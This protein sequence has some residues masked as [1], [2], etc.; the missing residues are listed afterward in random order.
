MSQFAEDTNL[1]YLNEDE[2]GPSKWD[3]FVVSVKVK[4]IT[5]K[6]WLVVIDN[7][8]YW[9]PKSRCHL[10]ENEKTVIIERWLCEKKGIDISA[11]DPF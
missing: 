10:D 11:Q 6:S 9:L 2:P 7:E 3:E 4:A 8:S 1:Y 5:K